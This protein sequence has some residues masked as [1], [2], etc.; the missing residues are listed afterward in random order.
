M[1][2]RTAALFVSILCLA[3]LGTLAIVLTGCSQIGGDD[4]PGFEALDNKHEVTVTRRDGTPW[5]NRPEVEIAYTNGQKYRKVVR[6]GDFV[7]EIMT[8]HDSSKGTIHEYVN[9][10]HMGD[11]I[12]T[13]YDPS[14]DTDGSDGVLRYGIEITTN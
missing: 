11:L 3:I 10:Y 1:K 7:A 4:S 12:F 9:V 6:E 2:H 5:L 8:P 14:W 13:I